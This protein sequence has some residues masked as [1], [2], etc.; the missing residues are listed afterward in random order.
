MYIPSETFK[1]DFTLWEALSDWADTGSFFGGVYSVILSSL[2]LG[3][4]H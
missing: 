2:T 4:T 1:I 3:L